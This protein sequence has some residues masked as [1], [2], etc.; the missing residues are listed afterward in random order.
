[1]D[2]QGA[3][4]GGLTAALT[5]R[6]VIEALQL[7]IHSLVGFRWLICES[8][9]QLSQLELYWLTDHLTSSMR[10][11]REEKF[12]NVPMQLKNG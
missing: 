8:N 7:M 2:V 6:F 9:L 5:E 10:N 4:A 12:P 1:M 11:G 3:E